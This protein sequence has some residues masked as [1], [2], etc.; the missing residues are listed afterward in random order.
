M[1]Q[2]NFH[3]TQTTKLM[4]FPKQPQKQMIWTKM[5]KKE[6]LVTFEL[7]LFASNNAVKNKTTHEQNKKV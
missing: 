6:H 7:T 2:T 3:L 1:Y 5:H 4:C